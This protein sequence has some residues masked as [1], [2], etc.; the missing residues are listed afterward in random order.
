MSERN[1]GLAA[2]DMAGTTVQ[3][4]GLVYSTLRS[5][6]EQETGKGISDEVFAPW[7][8]TGKRQAIVGLLTA[9][10]GSAPAAVVDRAYARFS[11]RLAAAYL[12]NP[13]V[14]IPGT[15]TALVKLRESGVKVVLQTGYSRDIAES[16]LAAVGWTI[17]GPVIDGLV[18]SD[19]VPASRPA[20][21]LI[22]RAMELAGVWDTKQVL[23]AGDTPND[24]GAGINA[25]VGFVV[26]VLSGA[27]SADTLGRL[28]HTHLL[29]SV[30]QLPELLQIAP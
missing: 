6:V 23:V 2:L 10:T 19:E 5:V 28:R 13:P 16:I 25:G 20:P 18:A 14:E 11:D 4:H 8:G 26:G 30:A 27:H 22:F 9:A 3:D 7:T 29:P 24:L 15:T 12:A 1:F 17:G 21:Y